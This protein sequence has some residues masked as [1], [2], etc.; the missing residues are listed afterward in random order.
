MNKTSSKLKHQALYPNGITVIAGDSII[1]GVIKK[2]I[3]KKETPVKVCK[4][5]GA[6]VVDMEH[7]LIPI[8]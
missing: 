1:N 2:K 4:F 6:T 5:S 7:Y 8:F 3:N